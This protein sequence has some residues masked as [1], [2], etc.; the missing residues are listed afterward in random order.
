MQHPIDLAV[1]RYETDNTMVNPRAHA[2]V[3]PLAQTFACMY[4]SMCVCVK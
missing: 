1:N 2:C 3:Y 4:A